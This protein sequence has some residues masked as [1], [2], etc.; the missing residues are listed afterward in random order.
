[1]E[2]HFSPLYQTSMKASKIPF[3]F[4]ST[5]APANSGPLKTSSRK[6]PQTHKMPQPHYYKKESLG[7]PFSQAERAGDSLVRETLL[8]ASESCTPGSHQPLLTGLTV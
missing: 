1:M 2:A 7:P 4:L 6:C 3:P 5:K 8:G